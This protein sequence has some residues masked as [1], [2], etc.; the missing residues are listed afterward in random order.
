MGGV[1]IQ[2]VGRFSQMITED[3]VVVGQDGCMFGQIVT[4]VSGACDFLFF[5]AALMR[6]IMMMSKRSNHA[7]VT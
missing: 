4:G 3:E 7:I 2:D 1:V 5:V 6:R